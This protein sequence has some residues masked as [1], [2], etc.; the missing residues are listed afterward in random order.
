M[1]AAATGTSSRRTRA[2][3][4]RALAPSRR[5]APARG[6]TRRVPT[7]AGESVREKAAARRLARDL[8]G[9]TMPPVRLKTVDGEPVDLE[10]DV[11]IGWVVSYFYP[12]TSAPAA[13]GPDGPAQDAA[14]HRAYRD[15]QDAFS[16]RDVRTL[17]ISSQSP[18]TQLK[19]ALAGQITHPLLNDPELVLADELG[20]PTFELGGRR[21]YRRLTLLTRDRRIERVFYPV[22]SGDR[23]PSQVL[24]WMQLNGA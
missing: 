5:H 1:S 22:A 6:L 16:A 8:T 12:G 4:A 14:Q 20:L 21:W 18:T 2:G 24:A 3:N 23:N 13:A 19:T 11:A 17:G 7:H 10:H 15:R 9:E